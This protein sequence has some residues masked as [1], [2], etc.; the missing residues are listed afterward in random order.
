MKP[1]IVLNLSL[2]KVLITACLLRSPFFPFKNVS[3]S[4]L[5]FSLNEQCLLKLFVSIIMSLTL[6]F[7]L[8]PIK[9]MLFFKMF[10]LNS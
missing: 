2:A 8:F 5:S 10:L 3:M 7:K 6:H 1:N 9:S 4:F